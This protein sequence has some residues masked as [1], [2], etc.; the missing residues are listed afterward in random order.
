MTSHIPVELV[1]AIQCGRSGQRSAWFRIFAVARWGFAH[2]KPRSKAKLGVGTWVGPR[3]HRRIAAPF[4]V[5]RGGR[6]DRAE[7]YAILDEAL[8]CHLAVTLVDGVVY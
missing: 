6:T 7:L 3:S 1:T 4:I 5:T 8:E 2:R